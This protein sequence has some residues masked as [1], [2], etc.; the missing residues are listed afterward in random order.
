MIAVMADPLES[1]G[2]LQEKHQDV[3]IRRMLRRY[4]ALFA[5]LRPTHAPVNFYYKEKILRVAH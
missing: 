2:R 5:H 4:P 1:S 3:C